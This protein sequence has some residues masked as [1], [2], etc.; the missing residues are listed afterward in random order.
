M[1]RSREEWI[2]R[3]AYALWEAEGRPE[4][5]DRE[6]WLQASAEYDQLERTKA[7]RDGKEVLRRNKARADR[8]FA[9]SNTDRPAGRR[10]A[11]AS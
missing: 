2:S 6:N 7:S 9:A 5:R 1:D 10:K 11:R 4:G 3:R 8:L